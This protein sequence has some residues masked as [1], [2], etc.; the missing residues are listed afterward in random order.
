MHIGNWEVRILKF[1]H[2]GPNDW[3]GFYYMVR[4]EVLI[5]DDD[6]VVLFLHQAVLQ[7]LEISEEVKT[8]DHGEH[9]VSYIRDRSDAHYLVLLDINMPEMDG[10]MVLNR[11]R[12][13][14]SF[15]GMIVLVT[16]SID[17]ADRLMAQRYPEV[18]AY[19]EKPLNR[20]KL[21]PIFQK[22]MVF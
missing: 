6:P 9:A 13:D 8:F 1:W 4:K 15:Q 10:W 22:F 18:F 16:S 20:E 11:L 12:A 7:K 17:V 3:D 21:L 2:F 14:T 19:L 5:I